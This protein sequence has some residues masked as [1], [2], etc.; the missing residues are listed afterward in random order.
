MGT[1]HIHSWTKTL[2]KRHL[3]KDTWKKT[4]GQRHLDKDTWTKTLGDIAGPLVHHVPQHAD[5]PQDLEA[6]IGNGR[7]SVYGCS[8]AGFAIAFIVGRSLVT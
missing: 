7:G 2:G 5:A 4:L 6:W 1:D 3:D 8:L